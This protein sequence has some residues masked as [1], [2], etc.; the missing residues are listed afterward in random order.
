MHTL[1]VFV[2]LLAA[3]VWIGG[4][5]AIGVASRVARAQLGPSARIA[6]FRALGTSYLRVGGA[7]LVVAL[8]VGAG[9]LAR[10]E[11]GPGKSV[12][13][14]IGIA[15]VVV[16]VVAIRQARSITRLRMVALAGATDAVVVADR[17]SRAATYLRATLGLLTI[18]ELVAASLLIH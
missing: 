16:T 18:S 8:L 9:L 4:F 2:E 3:S 10:G 5:V 6:F 14:A 7:A 13:V 12:T 1:L 17:R 15:L 11:W